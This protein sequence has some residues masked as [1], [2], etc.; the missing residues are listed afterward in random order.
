MRITSG[1]AV[2][3]PCCQLSSLANTMRMT[4][5]QEEFAKH[6][7]EQDPLRH[8][9]DDFFYP[10]MKDLVSSN[11]FGYYVVLILMLLLYFVLISVIN[12]NVVFC[13]DI[14]DQY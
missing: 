14:G 10:K 3:Y 1:P 5:E 13:I 4:V 12:T 11:F 9:R 7:D 8:L 2:T 6:L